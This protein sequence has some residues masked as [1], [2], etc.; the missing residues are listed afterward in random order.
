MEKIFVY[1]V[2]DRN[3]RE[4]EIDSIWRAVRAYGDSTLLYVRYEDAEHPNGTV[5]IVK[6]GL[7]VGYMDRFKQLPTGEL[8][9]APAKRPGSTVHEGSRRVARR[10][11]E[12]RADR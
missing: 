11:S 9:A 12:Q 4:E 2:T 3:L 10:V 5:A 7:M 1:R 6:P 8:T